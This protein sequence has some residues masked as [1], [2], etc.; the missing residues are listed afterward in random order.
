[1]THPAIAIDIN[2]QLNML[3]YNKFLPLGGI[4]SIYV[5]IQLRQE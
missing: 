2:F 1:M 5:Q 4:L 3:I